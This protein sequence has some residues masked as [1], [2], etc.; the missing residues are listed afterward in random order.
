[1]ARKIGRHVHGQLRSLRTQAVRSKSFFAFRV[2]IPQ[3]VRQGSELQCI[4]ISFY[5]SSSA[6][7]LFHASSK[8]QCVTVNWLST[9]APESLHAQSNLWMGFQQREMQRGG[10]FHRD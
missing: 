9:H 2:S 4:I 7:Y 6:S 5:S 3:M 10:D 8:L 1:M